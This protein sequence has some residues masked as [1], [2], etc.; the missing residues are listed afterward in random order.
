MV[1]SSDLCSKSRDLSRLT[2]EFII[3]YTAIKME[4][5]Q[6]KNS[7]LLPLSIVLAALLIGGALVYNAGSKE[8]AAKNEKNL[9][10]ANN[11]TE[12][13]SN[14]PVVVLPTIDDDAVMGD[15]NA[16]MTIIFF[17]DYQCPV[18]KV[19][20]D[21]VEKN[22]RK[23]YVDTGKAKIVFRDFPLDQIHEYARGAAEA[24]ECAKEQGKY[25]EYHDLL[26][27]KQEELG[28]IDFAV[29]AAGLGL[30]KSQFETC[31]NSRKYKDEVQKDLEDGIKAGVGGT[32]AT[33]IND[34]FISGINRIDPYKMFKDVIEEELAK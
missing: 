32:P 21:E 9:A 19:M 4:E 24:S 28:A 1:C 34:K 3:L 10:A 14:E 23:D 20:F 27:E 8:I 31:Y 18:C 2:I 11:P 26:Y 33:F 16:P 22:I 30:N 7:Y 25:W 17:G 5:N 13:K 29:L 12:E 6:N 15:T